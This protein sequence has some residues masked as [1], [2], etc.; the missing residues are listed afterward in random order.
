MEETGPLSCESL[1]LSG[2]GEVLTGGAEGDE[3]EGGEPTTTTYGGLSSPS[4]ISGKDRSHMLSWYLF[5]VAHVNILNILPLGNV[6]PVVAQ[7]LLA[8][9]VPLALGD[10]RH[11]GALEAEVETAD[12]AEQR[13]YSH[14]L[15]SS[16][17]A[18]RM[19]VVTSHS[20]P[21]PFFVHLHM[22]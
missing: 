18:G 7:H 2:E 10:S 22:A 11:P 4:A 13:D 9:R 1:A 21:H 15:T 17:C 16:S 19:I 3:V 5:T 20:R 14:E 12:A 6:G 8:L